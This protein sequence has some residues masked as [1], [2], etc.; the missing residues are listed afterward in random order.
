MSSQYSAQIDQLHKTIYNPDIS[1]DEARQHVL[2]CC[3][4]GLNIQQ[5]GLWQYTDDDLLRCELLLDKNGGFS[6]EALLLDR[7][8][9][10]GYF[11]ALDKRRVIKASDAMH[12]P[13]TKDLTELFLKPLNVKS[14]LD[15]PIYQGDK[16]TGI[17]CCE[18]TVTIKRWTEEDVAFVLAIADIYRS[19][20]S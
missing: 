9:F 7:W 19:R 17:I 15:V 13:A 14:L 18:Q 5:V 11:A 10:P 20:F 2:R 6:Q 3:L 1:E 16:L 4:D 8:S 12:D